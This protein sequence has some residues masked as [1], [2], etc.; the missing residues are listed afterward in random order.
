MPTRWPSFP[1]SPQLLA[2]GVAA[3]AEGSPTPGPNL[4]AGAKPAMEGNEQAVQVGGAMPWS[5]P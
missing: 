4:A 1:S 3:D 5:L 2:A